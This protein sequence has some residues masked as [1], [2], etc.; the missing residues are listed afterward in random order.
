[1]QQRNSCIS[2][3]ERT[4]SPNNKLEILPRYPANLVLNLIV[5]YIQDLCMLHAVHQ[6]HSTPMREH[7]VQRVF[8]VW[9]VKSLPCKRKVL[10]IA[11][12]ISGRADLPEPCF[13]MGVLC[14]EWCQEDIAMSQ[15]GITTLNIYYL[16]VI[17]L[18]EPSRRWGSKTGWKVSDIGF[19]AAGNRSPGKQ[20][21]R[22]WVCGSIGDGL[23]TEN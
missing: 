3:M 2:R 9:S 19:R 21:V 16:V 14:L 18:N 1:M 20:E 8:P 4:W 23:R 7:H 17:I 15:S 11:S 10:S 13:T 12:N 5:L 22:T 6:S